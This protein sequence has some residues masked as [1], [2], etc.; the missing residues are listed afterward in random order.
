MDARDW[1]VLGRPGRRPPAALA[2][3]GV[4]MSPGGER[5]PKDVDAASSVCVRGIGAPRNPALEPVSWF[6][7]AGMH[8]LSLDQGAGNLGGS[9]LSM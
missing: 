6:Q 1:P 7:P 9:C 4:A 2:T 3:L 8:P 5:G